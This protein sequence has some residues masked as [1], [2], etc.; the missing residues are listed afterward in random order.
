MGR[1]GALGTSGHATS[2]SC[3]VPKIVGLFC[4][5][6]TTYWV[7]N[8]INEQNDATWTICCIFFTP[9]GRP[10]FLGFQMNNSYSF[11]LAAVDMLFAF[12]SGWQCM[13]KSSVEAF[14]MN[15]YGKRGDLLRLSGISRDGYKQEEDQW[16][17]GPKEHHP[18]SKMKHR[19]HMSVMEKD[20]WT[21]WWATVFQSSYCTLT[22][23]PPALPDQREIRT[24]LTLRATKG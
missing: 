15:T 1:W 3:E 19:P 13:T 21:Q 14:E 4:H 11:S 7:I 8:R 5:C 17:G 18:H 20:F 6:C 16:S 9:L 10:H 12:P 2:K 22:P 23:T 24:S